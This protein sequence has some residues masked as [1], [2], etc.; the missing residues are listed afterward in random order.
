MNNNPILQFKTWFDEVVKKK[1]PYSNALVLSTA[2]KKGRPSS[3]VVLLKDFSEKGFVFYTNFNS[4]KAIELKDNPYAAM[5]FFWHEVER[6]VRIE[7]KIS[8]VSKTESD[9]Y[10]ATRERGSQAGAWVSPQS[11]VIKNR[12]ELEKKHNKLLKFYTN[13]PIPRP[14]FWGGYCLIPNRIEFWQGRENR[15]HDRTVYTKGEKGWKIEILAP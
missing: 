8:T 2:D 11:K 13:K 15:L 12:K 9:E 7:G 4:R 5:T 1:C 10:F 14:P 6:Q 3:R